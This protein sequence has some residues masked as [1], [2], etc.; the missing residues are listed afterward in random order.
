MGLLRIVILRR[1]LIFLFAPRF[2]FATG[3]ALFSPIIFAE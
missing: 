3:H 2:V 1:V